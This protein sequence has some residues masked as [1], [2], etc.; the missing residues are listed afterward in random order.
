M[1]IKS[2]KYANEPVFIQSDGT[3][4]PYVH[5]NIVTHRDAYAKSLDMLFKH[6]GD[7]HILIVE[8]LSEKT[9]LDSSEIMNQIK[10]DERMKNVYDIPTIHGLDFVEKTDV[11][12][13]IPIAEVDA[14]TQKMES[15]EVEPIP[16][17]R[18]YV[19]K[20]KV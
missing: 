1:S 2:V 15:M 7:F 13:I 3:I 10:N 5:E 11:E 19:K 9:G 16:K 14:L 18:K 4:I 8:I 20:A 12:K 6:V 17:K